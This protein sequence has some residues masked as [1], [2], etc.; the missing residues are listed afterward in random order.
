MGEIP[1]QQQQAVVLLQSLR[2]ENRE[3]LAVPVEIND[4]DL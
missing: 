4:L 2:T 3:N 1:E